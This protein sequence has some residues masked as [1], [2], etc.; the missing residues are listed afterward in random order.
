MGWSQE[1]VPAARALHVGPL[2]SPSR[3]ANQI[4]I[5]EIEYSCKRSDV[6][7]NEEKLRQSM[8]S[9]KGGVYSQQVVDGDIENL[10]QTGDHT[11]VQIITTEVRAEDGE[12]GVRLRVFV[13][14][15]V[16][17]SEVE[18][19]RR[20]PDGGLDD[21]L[22]VKREELIRVHPK[23][24]DTRD[25]HES[26]GGAG[27]VV[28]NLTVTKA[29]EILREERLFR[30]AVAMEEC[31][32]EKGYKD[33]RITPKTIDLK[34][35]EAK[36]VFEVE[37]GKLGFIVEVCFLGNKNV[38]SDELRKVVTLKPASSLSSKEESNCF[39]VE[40]LEI[41]L[42]RLKDLYAN[43][44]FLDVQVTASVE[45]FGEPKSN[46]EE[47]EGRVDGGAGESREDLSMVYRIVEGQRYGVEKIS[48]SGNTFFSE[49]DILKEL[50]SGAKGVE[51]FDCVQL[52][53]IRADGLTRGRAYSV[54]GLQ[55]SLEILQ[56][57]Y[58][59]EGFREARVEWRIDPGEKKGDLD[60][61]FKIAES[62]KFKVER[63]EI[64]GNTVTEDSLIRREIQLAPGEVF[65]TLKE[66]SSKENILKMGLF[67]SVETYAEETDRPHYQNLIIKV[68]EKPKELTFGF[69]VSYFWN[70]NTERSLVIASHFPFIFILNFS[71][72]WE[73][74]FGEIL[75]SLKQKC[76]TFLG[77]AM[78]WVR[79]EAC[80]PNY[81]KPR[82]VAEK[83]EGIGGED[84]GADAHGGGGPSGRESPT[85][86]GEEK[87]GGG[88][89]CEGIVG[90]G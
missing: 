16:R 84:E 57:M 50:R 41:D 11:N 83:A 15:R 89:E 72:N 34:G 37:E 54:N 7:L 53:M 59:R 9:K 27:A 67:S 17:V 69:G 22:S 40:K 68:V 60:I 70:G 64:L 82:G 13:D 5:L 61:H 55:A 10:Y 58:G 8:R 29:G 49:N 56:N 35:E 30:D 3:E 23:P 36:L 19:K 47:K 25:A 28:R 75:E 12:R 2:E 51:V 85:S 77:T 81:S 48:V 73:V 45:R 87:A 44:G 52:K 4:R 42:D 88:G 71:Q 18:V 65:N 76:R 43:K 39:K 14:P 46:E 1:V 38:G 33:V 74:V 86:R 20:R 80:V 6:V 24:W 66:K 32:R 21:N 31:Y 62:E 90:E 79:R 26:A 63:I 78:G